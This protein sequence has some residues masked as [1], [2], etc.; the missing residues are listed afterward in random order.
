MKA[1]ILSN[2]TAVLPWVR[3]IWSLISAIK[4]R[5]ESAAALA[6]ERKPAGNGRFEVLDNKGY[7]RDRLDQLGQ[8]TTVKVRIPLVAKEQETTS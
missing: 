1:W 2:R 4:R 5:A 3:G 8:G 6:A 7:V